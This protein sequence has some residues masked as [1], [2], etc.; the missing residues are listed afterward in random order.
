MFPKMELT[1]PVLLVFE[2]TEVTLEAV[3][4][5][6]IIKRHASNHLGHIFCGFV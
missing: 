3:K 2:T 4:C 1:D 5:E 6:V